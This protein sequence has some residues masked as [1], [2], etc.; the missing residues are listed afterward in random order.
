MNNRKRG[1]SNRGGGVWPPPIEPI[2]GQ[3]SDKTIP[4][5]K[6]VGLT[7]VAGVVCTA[8]VNFNYARV[9]TA[10]R[11]TDFWLHPLFFSMI[12]IFIGLCCLPIAI[13][14]LKVARKH[15]GS[16]WPEVLG[17]VL[18][19]GP[20]LFGLGYLYIGHLRGLEQENGF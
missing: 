5:I 12:A 17:V 11:G 9:L 13:D 3:T 10:R 14:D 2:E 15:S 4:W 18:T 8:V 6:R 19:L 16:I 7:H 1:L 20:L